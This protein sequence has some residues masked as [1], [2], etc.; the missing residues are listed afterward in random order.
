MVFNRRNNV[1]LNVIEVKEIID[2]GVTFPVRCRLSRETDAVVKYPKNP[3]GTSVLIN[4]WV[5]NS[6][7]DAIGLTIPPYGL[8]VL[9]KEVIEAT[10]YNEEID[11]DNSGICFYSKVINNTAPTSRRV[12]MSAKNKETERLLLFDHLVNNKDRHEGNLIYKVSED[13]AVYFIDCSHIVEPH[14]QTLN[15]P[16]DLDTELSDEAIL[17]TSLLTEENNIYN[18]LCETMGYRENV[19]Y[20]EAERIKKIITPDVLDSIRESIPLEWRGETTSQRIS[21]MFKVL[22]RRLV[23]INK[24]TEMVA[25]ERR[26]KQWKKY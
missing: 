2:E 9:S 18:I 11:T 23:N 12:L 16:L 17:N 22:E 21:D 19:L 20:R 5:G 25:R 15:H 10:N 4:E 8:C 1:R 26:T 24:I 7:A 14:G 3:S 6:I 13:R